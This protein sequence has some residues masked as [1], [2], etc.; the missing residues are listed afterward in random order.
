MFTLAFVFVIYIA[1]ILGLQF[2]SLAGNFR[3]IR[4]QHSNEFDAEKRKLAGRNGK[5]TEEAE[6]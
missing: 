5:C 4:S 2:L 6:D 1:L 3:S